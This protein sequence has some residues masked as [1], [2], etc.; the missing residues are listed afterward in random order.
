MKL[1]KLIIKNIASIEDAVLDFETAPLSDARIFLIGGDTGSGKSTILD[2]ICLALYDDTPRLKLANHKKNDY[3][4]DNISA[5]DTRNLM[6]H[7]A[8]DAMAQLLFEGDDGKIYD[9]V[10]SARR[11]KNF[12][13]DNTKRSLAI[14]GRSV[15]KKEIDTT[16]IKAVGLDFEQFCRVTMLAQGQ[17]TQFLKSDENKKAE[18]LEK[19]T[20]TER[21][22]EIGKTV[23]QMYKKAENAYELEK[24]KSE[25]VQLLSEEKKREL[26]EQLSEDEKEAVECS[27][28]NDK[29]AEKKNW[30]ENDLKN[31]KDLNEAAQQLHNC[32]SVTSSKQFTD[33]ERLIADWERSRE[34]RAWAS[35][36][37]RRQ[38]TLDTIVKQKEPTAQ[39]ILASLRQALRSFEDHIEA[40]RQ[41]HSTLQDALEKAAV[42]KQ[43]YDNAQTIK[44]TLEETLTQRQTKAVEEKRLDKLEKALPELTK[45]IQQKQDLFNDAKTTLEK[46]H[47]EVEKAETVLNDMKPQELL[48][49]HE[50]AERQA[51]CLH[52]AE[53]AVNRLERAISDQTSARQALADTQTLMETEQK[54]KDEG[55]IAEKERQNAYDMARH[56]YEQAKLSI[57]DEVE[58]LRAQLKV[59]DICPVCGQKID[60]LLSSENA[61]KTL[62][63]LLEP[64]KESE[65]RLQEA[66]ASVKAS[67]KIIED[68]NKKTPVLATAVKKAEKL[69]DTTWKSAKSS[70]TA[71]TI[72]LED[73]TPAS[74]DNVRAALKLK[75]A[76]VEN[77]KRHL[78][79][80]QKSINRQN[81]LIK[82]LK[83]EENALTQNLNAADKAANDAVQSEK[84][85]NLQIDNL[86]KSI[87]QRDSEISQHI[88]HVAQYMTDPTWQSA[89][90]ANPKEYVDNLM[91]RAQQYAKW[92]EEI[93]N[94]SHQIGADEAKRTRVTEQDNRVMELWPGWDTDSM[95]ITSLP[96]VPKDIETRWQKFVSDATQLLEKKENCQQEILNLEQKLKEFHETVPIDA[97]RLQEISRFQNM[98]ELK[99]SHTQ[100]HEGLAAARTHH[101]TLSKIYAEH[102][103]AEHPAIEEGETVEMLQQALLSGREKLENLNRRIGATKTTLEKDKSET[104]RLQDMLKSV[105]KLKSCAENWKKLDNLFGGSDGAKFRNIAQS[106]LLENLLRSANHYLQD[107]TKRYLLECIPGTLTISL[108]DQYMPDM[109]SP[110]DTLSGG[111][112]FLVSLALALALASMSRQGITMDTLFIDEGFGTLSDNEMDTV[113]ALLERLQERKGR[114]VGIISHVKELRERIPVHV[115]VSRID[116]TRSGI[117]VRDT[118]RA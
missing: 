23:F 100:L 112:G 46:K 11:T 78:N 97:A 19:M 7:G 83:D 17:F 88:E 89:W 26:V 102:H 51:A 30:L 13:L 22:S 27:K 96:D 28:A 67:L 64:L 20:K 81:E 59:G 55:T 94:L 82:A 15:D 108:R 39:S 62:D 50:K 2:A 48:I 1:K 45:E 75:F 4:S 21:Y 60:T 61:H 111:E 117:T 31:E 56:A 16:I 110:V 79:E 76:E 73:A 98:D 42:H 92:R 116:P 77:T 113:M 29:I 87:Q 109:V 44:T 3:G 24:S 74:I 57:A 18:I 90:E 54:K 68:C 118:T 105:E 103:G 36:L 65:K 37:A 104:E 63:A 10:W 6:R 52:E 101:A 84:T 95:S 14:D 114:R 53:E 93:V 99:K 86:K 35:D 8:K 80:Q 58:R 72:T 38:E 66:K 32:E 106:F 70:C 34:A 71:V 12:T 115:E 40:E 43:M 85:Q 69:V 91:A 49:D 47:Q 33:D 5:R 9:A 41:K 25:G 107:L